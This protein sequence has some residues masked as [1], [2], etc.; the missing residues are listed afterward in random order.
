MRT[1]GATSTRF[2]VSRSTTRRGFFTRSHGPLRAGSEWRVRRCVC[3]AL[4]AV[5]ARGLFSTHFILRGVLLR[6]TPGGSFKGRPPI[7]RPGPDETRRACYEQA[8]VQ[9]EGLG[10]RLLPAPRLFV[11]RAATVSGVVSAL[12]RGPRVFS[13]AAFAGRVGA[14]AE[15]DGRRVRRGGVAAEA[16]LVIVLIALVRRRHREV[17]VRLLAHLRGQVVAILAL[18]GEAH[19]VAVDMYCFLLGLELD[20]ATT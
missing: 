10:L 19:R 8:E 15:R 5:A 16:W 6:R 20:P 1:C 14:L 18:P 11:V 12:Q 3:G 2:A 9:H 7:H 13:G 17:R 4:E